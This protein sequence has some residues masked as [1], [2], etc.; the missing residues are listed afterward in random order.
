MKDKER[1]RLQER[2]RMEK[3][4]WWGA[5]ALWNYRITAFRA[6]RYHVQWQPT[7]P[8][9]FKHCGWNMARILQFFVVNTP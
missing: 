3:R 4:K 8:T 5:S 7:F 2:Q 6:Q 1:H 9:I